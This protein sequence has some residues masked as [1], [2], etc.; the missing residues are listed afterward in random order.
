MRHALITGASGGIGS[1]LAQALLEQGWS[2]TGVSRDS[3]ALHLVDAG[4]Q[5]VHAD[6]S[7]PAACAALALRKPVDALIVASGGFHRVKLMEETPAGWR[8]AFETG[9]DPLLWLAQG[10]MPGMMERGFG[11]IL[12]FSMA[13]PSQA[14]MVTAERIA[15]LGVE[16]LVKDLCALGA[17]HGVTANALALGYIDSGSKHAPKHLPALPAGRQGRVDEVVSAAML[18]LSDQGAYINGSVVPVAGGY[19][20]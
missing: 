15:R 6:V 7:K 17:P 2:V 14:P 5:W 20:A 11:R 8:R 9:L 10:V 3:T 13:G 4:A 19:G 1:A 18:L 12:A 16:A